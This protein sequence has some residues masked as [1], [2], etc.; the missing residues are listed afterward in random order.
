MS[1]ATGGESR[2]F[3]GGE[4][5]F[6]CYPTAAAKNLSMIVVLHKTWCRTLSYDRFPPENNIP[7]PPIFQ[8]QKFQMSKF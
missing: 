4:A 1:P 2:A 5:I 6:P 8:D 3:A 7:A